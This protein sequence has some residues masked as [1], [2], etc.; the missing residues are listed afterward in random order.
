MCLDQILLSLQNSKLPWADPQIPP[1]CHT[2]I[3]TLI[4]PAVETASFQR[5]E[6]NVFQQK[7][8]LLR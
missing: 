8:M 3:W 7:V 2:L 6:E 4:P 1:V 5:S